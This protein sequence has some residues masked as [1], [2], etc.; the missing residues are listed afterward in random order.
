MRRL[1]RGLTGR[2]RMPLMT[3]VMQGV[4]LVKPVQNSAWLTSR[5]ILRFRVSA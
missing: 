3:G 2:A 1:G 4:G 5:R